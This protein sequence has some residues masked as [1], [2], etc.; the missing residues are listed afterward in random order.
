MLQNLTTQSSRRLTITNSTT[1]STVTNQQ[2]GGDI[3]QMYLAL[4][5]KYGNIVGNTNT[6]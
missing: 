5:D 6:A 3:P 4:A 1:S 2:S